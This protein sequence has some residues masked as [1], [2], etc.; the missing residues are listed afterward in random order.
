MTRMATR[1]AKKKKKT[2]KEWTGLYGSI[3]HHGIRRKDR[4]Y[5]LR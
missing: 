5:G 3:G 2:P 1:R 4:G